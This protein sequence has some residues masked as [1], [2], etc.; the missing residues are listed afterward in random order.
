M[1]LRHVRLKMANRFRLKENDRKDLTL[2]GSGNHSQTRR[3]QKTNFK[4]IWF[5]INFPTYFG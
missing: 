2:M 5:F 4:N 3:L 1:S